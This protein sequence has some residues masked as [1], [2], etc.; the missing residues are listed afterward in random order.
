MLQEQKQCQNCP[1]FSS[2]IVPT[3]GIEKSRILDVVT[4]EAL[5]RSGQIL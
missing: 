4:R 3:I 2:T 1:D 5:T